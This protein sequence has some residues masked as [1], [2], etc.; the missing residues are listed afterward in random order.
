MHYER[1]RRAEIRALYGMPPPKEYKASP[2]RKPFAVQIN[3]WM[4]VELADAIEA[5]A[6]EAGMNRND[7]MR[8]ALSHTVRLVEAAS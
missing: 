3:L 2:R 8:A 6:A 5:A 7:W 4:S 1:I